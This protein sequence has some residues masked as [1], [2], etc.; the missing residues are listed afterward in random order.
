MS[1]AS[2][3]ESI[4]S[5]RRLLHAAS[6]GR[7]AGELV[8]A[9][10]FAGPLSRLARADAQ[11][12]ALPAV[13]TRV[14]RG[15]DALRALVLDVPPDQSPRDVAARV[16]R[17]L[18]ARVP[19][20]RWLLV[21]RQPATGTLLIAA[22]T[23]R[24]RGIRVSALAIGDG[25]V[26]DS[27][28]VALRA[29]AACPDVPGSDAVCHERWTEVLGRERVTRRFFAALRDATAALAATARPA[30]TPD[31][32]GRLA[33]L[34][35]C[36][37]LF[38][39]FL[40]TKGWLDGDFGFLV[41]G[42]A[43]CAA[44]G[45]AYHRRVL[46]PLLFG[47]LNTPLCRRAA[48]ARA[49]GRIPF[50]NGGLF[51]RTPLERRL[52]RVRFDD[53]A[54]ATLFADVLARFRFT[55]REDDDGWSDTA[56]DPEM[57]G[58]VFESLMHAPDRHGHGVFYTPPHFVHRIVDGALDH[59]L[60]IDVAAPVVAEGNRAALLHRVESLRVL[61]P[62]CG[63]GALL[64]HA[65]GRLTAVRSALGDARP[66]DVILRDV[67]TR[68]IHGVDVSATAVWLC[69]LRLWLATVVDVP[70]PEQGRVMPLPNLDRQIR[71]GDSLAGPRPDAPLPLPRPIEQLRT[72]YARAT[73]RRKLMLAR[74]LDALERKRAIDGATR[75]RARVDGER[76]ELLLAARSRD[77]FGSRN[78]RAG[79]A[80]ARLHALR[81]ER[82]RLTREIALLRDGAALP[83]AFETH[84]AAPDG[85]DVVVG[86]P[87]WVRPHR[88]PAAER[89]AYRDRYRAARSPAWERGARL[90]G[91]GAGFAG[92]V[93]LAALFVERAVELLHPG[94]TAALLVPAKLLRS[95]AGGGARTLLAGWA[96]LVAV[97]DHSEAGPH[98]EASTYPALL[99]LTRRDHD[100][101]R[102]AVAR[103][104][105][106]VAWH[107]SPAA[108][109]LD[110]TAGAPWVLLPPAARAAFDRLRDAGP[111][112]AAALGVHPRLGVKCGCNAAFLVRAEPTARDDGTTVVR[113]GNRVGRCETALLRPVLRGHGIAP[114]RATGSDECVVWTHD[115]R[116]QPLAELPPRAA[117][118]L[119]AHRT[120]LERRS[121]AR[122]GPIWWTLF[123]TDAAD[124]TRH[125]VVWGDI[126]RTMRAAL[127]PAHDPTVPLNTCYVLPLDREDDALALVA[128][129]NAPL[130]GAWLAQLAEPARG[131]Y[132]RFLGWT[133]ALLP[134][135]VD[136]PR[137]RELLAP[138]AR[139]ARRAGA[140]PPDLLDQAATEAYG[141]APPTLAPLLEWAR[142]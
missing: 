2:P 125:R 119:G 55:A 35:V 131:G 130:V 86:N 48:A 44:T 88:V 64:I 72:R 13:P 97:E 70:D 139:D 16:A 41:N 122:A 142:R 108:L 82:A 91:A 45:G 89:H 137:A 94:G 50:L 47:T 8:Q 83:F 43:R 18:D 76:R 27:D 81:A 102:V 42:F 103:G 138:L 60:G 57:L 74:E 128:L 132:H 75:L 67:L 28:A 30:A 124:R 11:L 31:D 85:F 109:P 106:E 126:A 26:S 63:S 87:P 3:L 12:L 9:L 101:T 49:F 65:A 15:R 135:P 120:T 7:S 23:R 123:R 53:A 95:L 62:A 20:L 96:A 141:V 92:Q 38:L 51:T 71:V 107:T 68:S 21:A 80:G 79:V 5:T 118:W 29:L 98:F 1:S 105:D 99:V 134:L 133:V 78:S 24:D 69:Q 36:R 136:W 73:G 6:R 140:P 33:L 77:L 19:H 117:A 14:A 113:D 129:L 114:W 115:A 10:G 22:W 39:S 110:R 104:R 56:V 93:D 61:D 32:A 34:A 25:R 90:A 58:R 54:L 59:A 40:E 17:E 37:L 46:D 111:P 84:F 4:A 100:T 112:L 52:A 66:R 127:L 116:D 121:D